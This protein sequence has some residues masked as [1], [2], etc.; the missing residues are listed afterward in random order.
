[1]HWSTE[2]ASWVDAVS[3]QTALKNLFEMIMTKLIPDY[4]AY[5]F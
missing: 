4:A 5:D 3:L 1:M 2:Q